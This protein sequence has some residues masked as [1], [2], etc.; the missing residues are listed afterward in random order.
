MNFLAELGKIWKRIGIYLHFPVYDCLSFSPSGDPEELPECCLRMDPVRVYDVQ[1]EK[2][3]LL[4]E[5]WTFSLLL[6]DMTENE[7]DDLV[8]ISINTYWED[9]TI[10]L[11]RFHNQVAWYLSVTP[12]A[13]MK[14]AIPIPRA[15]VFRIDHEFFIM[16]RG[17]WQYLPEEAQNRK[18]ITDIMIERSCR[19]LQKHR[20]AHLLR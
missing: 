16:R 11:P 3:E 6:P 5:T 17:Q 8:C 10:V 15:A 1:A 13:T 2:V 4:K 20:S 12:T 14:D 9:V 7:E 18:F 19:I